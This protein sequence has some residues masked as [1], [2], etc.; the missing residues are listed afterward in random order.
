MSKTVKIVLFSSIGA[1]IVASTILFPLITDINKTINAE[2]NTHT[3]TDQETNKTVQTFTRE[4]SS[5][6][7]AN[8]STTLAENPSVSSETTTNASNLYEDD[9]IKSTHLQ[10]DIP[11][12]RRN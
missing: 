9:T 6:T 3:P 4:S 10:E 5:T 12:Y 2:D 7:S 11:Q 8:T 1:F